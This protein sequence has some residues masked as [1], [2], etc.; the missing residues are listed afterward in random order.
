M[1]LLRHRILHAQLLLP[2][3][4]MSFIRVVCGIAGRDLALD[5]NDLALRQHVTMRRV[6]PRSTQTPR[7]GETRR[8]TTCHAGDERNGGHGPEQRWAKSVQVHDLSPQEFT[9]MTPIA[10][11][12]L[13][14][15]DPCEQ[16][17]NPILNGSAARASDDNRGLIESPVGRPEL[18]NNTENRDRPLK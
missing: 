14:P 9:A 15:T 2:A 16:F 13:P 8:A 11:R 18:R 5:G 4:W 3:R 10:G 17:A 12:T 7:P 1:I 6:G